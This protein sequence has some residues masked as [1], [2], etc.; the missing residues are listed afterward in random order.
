MMVKADDVWV[1]KLVERPHLVNEIGLARGVSVL[2]A[3]DC[4]L[5][6][7]QFVISKIHIA[8]AT[9]SEAADDAVLLVQNFSDEVRTHLTAAIVPSRRSSAKPVIA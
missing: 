4:D 6:P 3:L 8:E 2:E 7:C 5:A 1:V 9:A